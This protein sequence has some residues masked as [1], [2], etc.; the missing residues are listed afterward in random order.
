MSNQNGGPVA[1]LPTATIADS[2]EAIN[3]F[4]ATRDGD[5]VQFVFENPEGKKFG[6]A[7]EIKVAAILSRLCARILGAWHLEHKGTLFTHPVIEASVGTTELRNHVTVQFEQ[8][9]A[10]II[11]TETALRL[12]DLLEK[13]ALTQMTE[14]DRQ[15]YLQRKHPTIVVPKP[16]ILRP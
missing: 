1:T 2:D 12:A 16:K 14:E 11:N 5:K 4:E 3:R 13:T 6:L 7:F 9:V 8:G 15:K 10:Y